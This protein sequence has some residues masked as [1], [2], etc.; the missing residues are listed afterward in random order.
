MTYHL[1]TVPK[2]MEV[3][4]ANGRNLFS[5]MKPFFKHHSVEEMAMI[6]NYI[7]FY[8]GYILVWGN[9]NP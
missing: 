5:P 3:V 1:F 4:A 2:P 6:K 8:K 7:W 9:F